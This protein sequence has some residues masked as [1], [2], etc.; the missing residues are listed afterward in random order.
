MIPELSY[1]PPE[2]EDER[3]RQ[4][5]RMPSALR[6][7]AVH[8]RGSRFLAP[9]PPPAVS[10]PAAARPGSPLP[11]SGLSVLLREHR[12]AHGTTSDERAAPQSRTCALRVR[13]HRENALA[14]GSR[15]A[16]LNDRQTPRSRKAQ[17]PGATRSSAHLTAPLRSPSERRAGDAAC[18][19]WAHPVTARP[20]PAQQLSY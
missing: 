4:A 16:K 15:P 13:G 1:F 9:P 6:A 11:P 5:L 10:H 19:G 20:L 2:K 8:T 12:V 14:G 17:A 18:S 7:F 3:K